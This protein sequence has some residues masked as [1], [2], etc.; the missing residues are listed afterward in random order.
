MGKRWPSLFRNPTSS[1]RKTV[2]EEV[3]F[4]R[5]LGL[6]KRLNFYRPLTP[7]YPTCFALLS[8]HR[9]AQSSLVTSFEPRC[10]FP[11]WNAG[12]DFSKTPQRFFCSI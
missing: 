1:E 8:P 7:L 10:N 3:S 6:G 11:R 5:A 2:K 12:T 9:A 4:R